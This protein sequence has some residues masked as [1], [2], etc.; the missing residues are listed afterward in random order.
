MLY[1]K[2]HADLHLADYYLETEKYDKTLKHITASI[3]AVNKK[4]YN[5]LFQKEILFK[6]NVFDFI[7]ENKINPE[8]MSTVYY[9]V[10]DLQRY[11]WV[12]DKFAMRLNRDIDKFYDIKVT[13]F[14]GLNI[15][16]R[17]KSIPDELWVRKI[18]K[19]IFAYIILNHKKNLTKDNLIELFYPESTPENADNI[20]HQTLSNIRSIIRK[21]TDFYIP[22]SKSGKWT[23][24][25]IPSYISYHKQILS[26]NPNYLYYID[27]F[28]FESFCKKST[29]P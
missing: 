11:D 27:A 25:N 10:L 14:G 1:D 18:R 21:E 4:E 15:K 13:T 26:L 19:L 7:V 8:M 22:V 28:E 9:R 29:S 3:E 24:L 16:I 17:G 12:S 20:F 6:R 23:T 5:S 2:A